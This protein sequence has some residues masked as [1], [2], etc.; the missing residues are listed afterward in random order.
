MLDKVRT[1]VSTYARGFKVTGAF[2]LQ[3]FIIAVT[4]FV[5]AHFVKKAQ[6]AP[7]IPAPTLVENPAAVKK[8]VHKALA[9]T[10]Q[11]APSVIQKVFGLMSPAPPTHTTIY[12]MYT[13]LDSVLIANLFL[14]SR[15][16]V[17]GDE[18]ATISFNQAQKAMMQRSFM[19]THRDWDIGTNSQGPF[20]NEYRK[21]LEFRGVFLGPE[22][23][24]PRG[25]SAALWA[26]VELFEIL[27]VQPEIKPTELNLKVGWRVW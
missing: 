6:P 9:D 19:L 1:F 26:D 12:R 20:I 24:F 10:A 15:V 27:Q 2:I 23:S 17:R 5:T 7:V 11:K 16:S 3:L 22:Y 8:A 13:P 21:V 4:V 18:V 25:L 14:M